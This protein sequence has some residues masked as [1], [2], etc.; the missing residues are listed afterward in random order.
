MDYKSCFSCKNFCRYYIKRADRVCFKPANSGICLKIRLSSKIRND[1][2]QCNDCEFWEELDV[3]EAEI[4]DK[5]A[6]EK[7]LKKALDIIEN[8]ALY[9]KST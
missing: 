5:Q 8:I 1:Y 3:A 9:I 2:F 4:A 6:I 7:Q